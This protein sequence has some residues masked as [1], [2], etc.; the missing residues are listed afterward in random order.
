MGGER[1]GEWADRRRRKA[2]GERRWGGDRMRSGVGVK[3]RE[4]KFRDW[5][6]INRSWGRGRAK[7]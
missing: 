5:A 4:K 2:G 6:K 7:Q 3:A 1:G